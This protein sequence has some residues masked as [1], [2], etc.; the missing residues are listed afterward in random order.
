MLSGIMISTQLLKHLTNESTI[1]SRNNT[2]KSKKQILPTS[3]PSE[4]TDSAPYK[5]GRI[6]ANTRRAND[7][8]FSPETE[9]EFRV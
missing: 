6:E 4:L 1:H 8:P 2:N 9:A 3:Y 5:F 7:F